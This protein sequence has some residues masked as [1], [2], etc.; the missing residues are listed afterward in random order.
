[1]N[2]YKKSEKKQIEI[3][4]VDV[5][6]NPDA[7]KSYGSAILHEIAPIFEETIN[8]WWVANGVVGWFKYKDGKVYEVK[9]SEKDYGVHKDLLEESEQGKL[10]TEEP[11]DEQPEEF[12]FPYDETLD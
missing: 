4:F 11:I 5:P 9:V 3:D 6:Y 10:K 8:S 12:E 2:W 7:I 1:M